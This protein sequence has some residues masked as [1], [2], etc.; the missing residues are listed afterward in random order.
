[1][2]SRLRRI[3]PSSLIAK[4]PVVFPDFFHPGCQGL[5]PVPT[6]FIAG[7]EEQEGGMMSEK[8][9]DPPALLP[10][11]PSHLLPPLPI[12]KVIPHAAFHQ[13]IDILPVGSTKSRLRR[14]AGMK[15]DG[16]QPPF[17]YDLHLIL[18]PAYFRDRIT[19]KGVLPAEMGGPE[20]DRLTIHQEPSSFRFHPPYMDP[21]ILLP[22][23]YPLSV[24]RFRIQGDLPGH[25]IPCGTQGIR[26][27]VAIR[28][29]GILHGRVHTHPDTMFPCRDPAQLDLMRGTQATA[30]SAFYT[31]Y[32]YRGTPPGQ[33]REKV[34]FLVTARLSCPGLP[35][36]ISCG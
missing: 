11:H 7:R 8:V 6:R 32:P 24:Y 27:P 16:I 31:V 33:F 4:L 34:P 1:M 22:G 12:G 9:Q 28:P 23:L 19:G 3:E 14:T 13:Q 35:D 36:S 17:L 5:I 30:A 15:T 10:E 18:P 21:G 29:V 26:Y 25:T 2:P 20:I